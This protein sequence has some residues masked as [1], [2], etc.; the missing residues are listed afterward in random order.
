MR[1]VYEVKQGYHETLSFS[2]VFNTN[3][4]S[5]FHLKVPFFPLPDLAS[6]AFTY[7]KCIL[8]I[9]ITS[10][11][12]FDAHKLLKFLRYQFKEKFT[13]HKS[14]MSSEKMVPLGE[15]HCM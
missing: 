4:Y 11:V 5:A 6:R 10:L 2:S 14:A 12:P 1:V 13:L 15:T 7:L 3:T 8:D 9:E